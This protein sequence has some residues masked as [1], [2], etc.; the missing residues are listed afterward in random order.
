MKKETSSLESFMW[1]IDSQYPEMTKFISDKKDNSIEFHIPSED[2]KTWTETSEA[3]SP[4]FS[5]PN[6]FPIKKSSVSFNEKYDYY[7]V[8]IDL[9]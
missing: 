8:L 9:R 1:I 3:I 7:K 2:G 4:L 5:T 6:I